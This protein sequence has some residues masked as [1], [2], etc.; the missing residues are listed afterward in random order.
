MADRLLAR[1]DTRGWIDLV[2]GENGVDGEVERVVKDKV[3]A[4]DGE[5]VQGMVKRFFP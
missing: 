1:D 3:D 2:N 4:V 5:D